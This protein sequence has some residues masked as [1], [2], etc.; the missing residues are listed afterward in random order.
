MPKLNTTRHDLF[1][2][3]HGRMFAD[4]LNDSVQPSDAVLD[5]FICGDGER[6]MPDSETHYE[7]IPSAGV[8][9]ELEAQPPVDDLFSSKHPQST[10]QSRQAMGV[11]TDL[12]MER[13]GWKQTGKKSYLWAFERR[14]AHLRDRSEGRNHRLPSN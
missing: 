3:G 8:V 6:P 13:H 9:Q 1:Q 5:F 12:S 2:D 10:K 14:C 11:V 7:P 4:L